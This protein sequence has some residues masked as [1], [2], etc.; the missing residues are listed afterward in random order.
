[1]RQLYLFFERQ[2]WSPMGTRLTVSHIRELF[3]LKNPNEINYYNFISNKLNLTRDELRLRIKN[4]EYERL[5]DETK[6]K[7]IA[8]CF[9][10]TA[11]SS[12]ATRTSGMPLDLSFI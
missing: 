3:T 10:C 12:T 2:K 8:T 6:S 11:A 7:L 4:N 5:D 9:L 1:M